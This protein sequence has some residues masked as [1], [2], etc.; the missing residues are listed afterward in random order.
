MVVRWRGCIVVP[1]GISITA[2]TT[3]AVGAVS[4]TAVRACTQW[5]AIHAALTA[6]ISDRTISNGPRL[7]IILVLPSPPN[8]H[9]TARLIRVRVLHRSHEIAVPRPTQSLFRD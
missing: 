2:M 7:L 4:A 8:L 6:N 9:R 5:F 1:N 3:G